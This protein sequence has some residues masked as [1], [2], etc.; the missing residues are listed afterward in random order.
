M[1]ACRAFM[2]TLV[3]I[4]QF[5]RSVKPCSLATRSRLTSLFVQR[6][7]ASLP[8]LDSDLVVPGG[9]DLA[10]AARLCRRDSDQVPLLVGQ[11]EK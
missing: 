3:R 5:F 11:R 10:E 4:R 2:R 7:E 9:G 8:Q 1:V 6:P